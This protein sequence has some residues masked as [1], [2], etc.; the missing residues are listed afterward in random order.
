M[1]IALDGMGGDHAPAV[2]VE[3]ALEALKAAGGGLELVLVG[4]PQVLEAELA[5]LGAPSSGLTIHPA[6]QVAGMQDAPSQV[7]R[8]MPDSSIRVAF[9]LLKAGEVQAVVSAGNSGATMAVGM[10]VMG[11]MPEVDRPALASVLPGPHGPTVV[12]DVGANV[13]CSPLMLL[14]FGY[15]GAVYAERVLGRPNPAVGLLSIGEEDVKGNSVVKQAHE[16]FKNSALNF[17]GNVEGRDIFSGKAQVVVCD[18]FVG[19][20]C[21]KLAEGLAEAITTMFRQVILSSLMGKMG[22]LLM[23]DPLKCLAN[24]LDYS[25]YGGAPLL[26]ING[27]A[28]I[29]HGASSPRA[30]ASALKVAQDSVTGDLTGYLRQGLGRYHG[31]LLGESAPAQS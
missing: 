31:R 18:G 14:Q 11:R 16:Y 4:Q 26:G 22:A 3:G 20:V 29:C 15:M 13:D 5:R 28:F 9:N 6:S 17:V 25:T 27:L 30:I 10:V 21:L 12:V 1:R 24:R 8:Q 7:L 19:N 23:R 2:V